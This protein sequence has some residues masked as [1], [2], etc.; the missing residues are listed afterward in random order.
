MQLAAQRF[1][2]RL[3]PHHPGARAGKFCPIRGDREAFAV[4]VDLQHNPVCVDRIPYGNRT[5]LRVPVNVAHGLTVEPKKHAAGGFGE[6]I[7]IIYQIQVE[8]NARI[9]CPEAFRVQLDGSAEP[10]TQH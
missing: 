6:Q 9:I 2:A 4:I 5:G 10:K 3:N 8:P 1:E 7:F